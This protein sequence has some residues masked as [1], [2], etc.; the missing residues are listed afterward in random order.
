ML[1]ILNPE[2][3]AVN[4]KVLFIVGSI[5]YYLLKLFFT[6]SQNQYIVYNIY[7]IIAVSF[8]YNIFQRKLYI[9]FKLKAFIPRIKKNMLGDYLYHIYKL[10]FASYFLVKFV[11]RVVKSN[12][13]LFIIPSDLYYNLVQIL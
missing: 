6:F 9:F 4:F 1:F 13:S 5:V 8:L 10:F 3:P 7:T 12:F 11:Q 2:E